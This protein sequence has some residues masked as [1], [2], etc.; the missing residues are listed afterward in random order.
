MQKALVG[1]FM[2]GLKSEIL[3]VI[4]LFKPQSLKETIDLARMPNDQLLR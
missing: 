2:G 1:T 3:D 4:H